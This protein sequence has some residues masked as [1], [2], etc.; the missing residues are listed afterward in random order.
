MK[1]I[2]VWGAGAIGGTVAAH[3]SRARKSPTLV[4]VNAAHLD[5]INRDGLRISSPDGEFTERLTALAPEQVSGV[6][7]VIFLAV[8]A[9]HTEIALERA[10]E[11]LTPDGCV[12]SLQNGL[13]EIG[14]AELVGRERT[15]GAFINFG[16]DYVEP[17]HLLFANRGV[18]IIG[19]IDGLM[20]PRTQ[21]IVELLRPFEPDAATTDNIWGYLWGKTAYSSLLKAEALSDQTMVDF[22]GDP[23]LREVHVKLV[24]E[25][26]AV[27]RAE[28]VE[29][30]GFNGFDPRAFERDDE[31]AYAN[32]ADM[33]EFYR[34]SA[35]THSSAWRDIAIFG[36][37]TDAPAQLTPVFA[38]AEKHGLQV[39]IS[40][41][42]VQLIENLEA[43]RAKQG[44]SLVA[45]LAKEAMAS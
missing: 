20:R 9:T 1:R 39:P 43:G 21:R 26:L 7:D 8:K 27:A 45:E 42:L 40:R 5:A 33:A 10:R 13:C 28:G 12:V 17:G 4:D 25:L 15:V 37:K 44:S 31:A 32:L 2:L 14:I 36:Q 38:I 11:F 23:D 22:I 30:L 35:K 19:E 3:L 6:F 18:V 29:P 16:A 41:K 24:R 34:P